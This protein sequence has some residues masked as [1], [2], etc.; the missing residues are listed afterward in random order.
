MQAFRQEEDRSFEGG[1]SIQFVGD[2]LTLAAMSMRANFGS[3][4]V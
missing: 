3:D 2:N 4:W 1:A